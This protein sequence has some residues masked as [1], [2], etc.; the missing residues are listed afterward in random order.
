M[1]KNLSSFSS[2]RAIMF[3]NGTRLTAPFGG[4][5]TQWLN[6]SGGFR[7]PRLPAQEDTSIALEA[8]LVEM[9]FVEQETIHIDATS[10]PLS[11]NAALRVPSASEKL[12]LEPGRPSVT[13]AALQVVLYV[14]ESGGMSWHLP[15]DVSVGSAR[16]TTE[17]ARVLRASSKPVFTIPTRTAAARRAIASGQMEM[18]GWI[19]AIGRK[20]LKV[21]VIPLVAD[22]LGSPM[23]KIVA[24]VERKHSQ[25]LIRSVDANNYRQK[26]SFPFS[27]WSSL[28]GNRSLLV[29]HGI[30]SSTEG[31]LS[32]LPQP[33]MEALVKQ[34]SG[35][36]IAYDHFTLSLDPDENAT[37]FLKHVKQA[38]PNENVELDILCHSR[39]GIVSRALTER[40]RKLVP[41]HNCN[42]RRVLFVATPNAGSPL[43]NAEHVV[44]MVDVF[45]N[46]LTK[47]PDSITTYVVE[48]LL[49]IIKLIAYTAETA[50]PGL[51]AMGTE[52]YIKTLLNIDGKAV[53]GLTYGAAAANYDPDPNSPRAFC[54]AALN[55]VADR[56]FASKGKA[57]GNDLVVPCDGVFAQNG[58]PLFAIANPL[59]YQTSDY[60]YHNDFFAQPRTI[61]HIYRF[62][63]IAGTDI[64]TLVMPHPSAPSSEGLSVDESSHRNTQGEPSDRVNPRFDVRDLDEGFRGGY[65]GSTETSARRG[66]SRH[67]EREAI[68]DLS[69]VSGGEKNT[70]TAMPPTEPAIVLAAV[71]LK[72]D[73]QIEFHERVTEGEPNELVVRL[74]ELAR[75]YSGV[76]N[77]LEFA[78]AAGQESVTVNVFLSAVGFDVVPPFAPLTVNRKRDEEMEQATFTLTA[79]G[80]AKPIARS[81]HAD[82]F[83]GNSLIGSVT[84]FT[85][86]VPKNYQG[87]EYA[88]QARSEGF[89]VP[90]KARKE[91]DWA[92]AVTG[93]APTYKIFLTSRIEE[94]TFDFRDMGTLQLQENDMAKYL[95][96]VLT[97]QFAA[98][99]RKAGLSEEQY[100]AVMDTWKK[101]FMSTI[102]GVGLRLW[103]WLPQSL[104]D[105]YFR[106]YRICKPPRSIL[107]HSED[108][109]FPW[110][111]LIPNDTSNG[112]LI[113]LQ[114]LGIE[115]VLGRW[116]PG[117]TT[118]PSR[119][120]LKVRKF[121]VLNPNYPEPNTLKWAQTE[122]A[123]LGRLFPALV[124][125]V[126]PADLHGVQQLFEETDVQV[127]HFSGHGEINL[128]NPDLNKILLENNEEFDALGL[129]ATKLCAVAQPVVYLNACSVGNV[130]DTVGRAGGF[131]SNFVTN[132]CSG[133][134]A[135]LWP[136]N[137]YRS[138]E[139]A[140]SLYS[141]LKLG[142]AIGEALQ[143]LREENAKDPT[144]YAYTYFGDPWVRLDL[145]VA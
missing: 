109:I 134:I 29:I 89:A 16:A 47:L 10:L 104:R 59:V 137:D 138:M 98:T 108:M 31:M 133:V 12:V 119:Q 17:N 62:L 21:L 54:A 61:G 39:G 82:F 88:G 116:K 91:C 140:I 128:N 83:L 92:L 52:G 132:G 93:Q 8:A 6:D 23:E 58:N 142:R 90:L 123:E 7:A 25:N 95:N 73:P 27:N 2:S 18:R 28:A 78:L 125:P 114:S 70:G 15:D 74:R 11:A 102:E 86:V 130:G 107:I 37:F 129:V 5:A 120:M 53:P 105:E 72:R 56:T 113:K 13:Q 145:A 22:L 63:E 36:V 66:G 19:T 24:A 50:L 42:F 124:F 97:S 110:E 48:A 67:V 40:G 75:A 3:P 9:G 139:F 14:D 135:P 127:L 122:A 68:P 112:Q 34:Y 99:P 118:K 32:R 94:S 33:A 141:K 35:R 81:I 26:V 4:A 144:Y 45:T 77:Q 115:H 71:E 103:Q 30:I 85:Y 126:V 20:V 143:E 117:L 60:V 65:G 44:D 43:G 49:G 57:I 41:D 96:D 84:H 46:F 101:K 131:A 69:A 121:R 55:A 51:A 38:I 64:S 106:Q 100:R 111:L 1:S 79:R 136:V 76:E 80:V 87:P